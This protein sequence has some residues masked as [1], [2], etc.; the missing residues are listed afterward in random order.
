MDT[1]LTAILLGI[2][3]GI[4]EFIPVSSTG[5][6]IL[7]TEIFGYDAKTWAA[8]NVVIQLGA[9]LAILT[10]YGVKVATLLLAAAKGDG[11]ALRGVVSVRVGRGV[12]AVEPTAL[13]ANRVARPC[14]VWV[15]PPSA[16][17][18]MPLST[19]KPH[20]ANSPPSRAHR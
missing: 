13:I 2:V 16:L 7:A 14:L 11:V 18:A 8:F 17:N 5:H 10:L 12:M 1:I 20:C 19:P 6:L 15:M 4:T 3:E 9:V